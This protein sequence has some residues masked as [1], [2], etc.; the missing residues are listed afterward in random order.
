MGGASPL[1]EAAISSHMHHPPEHHPTYDSPIPFL[2]P[3]EKRAPSPSPSPPPQ[4]PPLSSHLLLALLAE[5]LLVLVLLQAAD[6]AR[7]ALRYVLAVQLDLDG[8]RLGMGGGG[9]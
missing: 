6:D 2:P 8:A 3:G 9:R 4:T 5:V 7:L 1:Q